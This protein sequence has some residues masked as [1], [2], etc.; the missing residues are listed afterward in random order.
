MYMK[1]RSEKQVELRVHEV[2]YSALMYCLKIDQPEMCSS[3]LFLEYNDVM[4]FCVGC[5]IA[6]SVMQHL[7]HMQCKWKTIFTL[8][9]TS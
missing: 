8:A 2:M 6:Q 3:G 9:I 1:K 5:N 4:L 7:Y